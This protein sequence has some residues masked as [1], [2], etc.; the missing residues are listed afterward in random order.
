MKDKNTAAILAL[1]LG[2]IG[3]HKFYLGQT[4]WGL[5]YLLF[6]WTMFPAIAAF[7]EFIILAV[8]DNDEF[9]RRFN[10]SNMLPP[11]VVNMLPP[12]GYAPG[13]PPNPYGGYPQQGGYPPNPQGYPQPGYPGAQP[14]YPQPGQPAPGSQAPAGGLAPDELARKLEKLNELRISGLL[15]E[16]EFNQQKAR[17]LGQA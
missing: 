11:V 10:G 6:S 3:V 12:A 5:V 16:D 13:Y 4:G 8:M 2:A 15:S 1:F 9:N 17:L 14:G 7:I